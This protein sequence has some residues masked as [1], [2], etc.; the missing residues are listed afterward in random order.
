MFVFSFI[1]CVFEA[2]ALVSI[3]LLL[4]PN[5]YT[6]YLYLALLSTTLP[7][8][9]KSAGMCFSLPTPS[10]STSTFSIAKFDVTA[11]F[12][13]STHVAPFKAAFG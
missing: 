2:N 9:L 8:L 10:W 6:Q 13:V 12:D 7:N 5:Y 3:L 11:K 4:W 1:C